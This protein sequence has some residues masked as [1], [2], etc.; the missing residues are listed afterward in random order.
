MRCTK[1]VEG[2]ARRLFSYTFQPTAD[3]RCAYTTDYTNYSQQ[4]FKKVLWIIDKNRLTELKHTY[5]TFFSFPMIDRALNRL[6]VFH[7]NHLWSTSRIVWLAVK[8]W[9]W[10]LFSNNIYYTEKYIHSE[11]QLKFNNKFQNNKLHS[12]L[13]RKVI[14][15]HWKT[16]FVCLAHSNTYL[17]FIMST[18]NFQ[19]VINQ[20]RIGSI[21]SMY[22][23]VCVF[24][25]MDPKICHLSTIKNL[26][27]AKIKWTFFVLGSQRI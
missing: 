4:Q 27:D 15:K 2:K 22:N 19:E 20:I 12:P 26:N 25:T 10:I 3:P 24:Y 7:P 17:Y 13:F 8:Q 18:L 16:S 21:V 6:E 14:N 5:L 1:W 23:G 11:I 9:E